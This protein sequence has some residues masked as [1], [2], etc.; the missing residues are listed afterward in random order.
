MIVLAFNMLWWISSLTVLFSQ[1]AKHCQTL[2]H[3]VHC[4]VLL[5]VTG[6]SAC[7]PNFRKGQDLYKNHW[8]GESPGIGHLLIRGILWR[9]FCFLRCLI[10]FGS[11]WKQLWVMK[12]NHLI[13]LSTWT[14]SSDS[15][16]LFGYP[17]SQLSHPC[18]I[19]KKQKSSE[20]SWIP[21]CGLHPI[22]Y[23]N[24]NF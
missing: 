20:Q 10:Q 15:A 13:D 3:W 1:S 23:M 21:F 6:L 5:V 18:C 11:I 17:R 9:Y 12:S 16:E 24:L 22:G 19:Q 7:T 4:A 8:D 2:V 14:I